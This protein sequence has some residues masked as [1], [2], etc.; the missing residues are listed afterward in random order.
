MP[1]NERTG[2][3]I[4]ERVSVSLPL[5]GGTSGDTFAKAIDS[6]EVERDKGP[7][8]TRQRRSV[9]S[10]CGSSMKITGGWVKLIIFPGLEQQTFRQYGPCSVYSCCSSRFYER[11][12][13]QLYNFLSFDRKGKA[14]VSRFCVKSR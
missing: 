10:R 13:L 3:K 2:D 12:R 4:S 11:A 5:R 1:R 9:S 7:R 6:E 14:V 8:L